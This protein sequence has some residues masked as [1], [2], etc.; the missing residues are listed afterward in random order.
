[1]SSL[2]ILVPLAGA[3]IGMAAAYG[4]THKPWSKRIHFVERDSLQSELEDLD[5]DVAGSE[6]CVECG[7]EIAPDEIGA[8]VRVDGEYQVVCDKFECLDT[9]DVETR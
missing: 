1:M 2:E 9:Y 3:G 8:V 6:T 4:A 7:D 5:V